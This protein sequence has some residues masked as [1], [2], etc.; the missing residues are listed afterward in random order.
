VTK[1]NDFGVGAGW[2]PLT[3]AGPKPAR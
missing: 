3:D 2:C 1:P